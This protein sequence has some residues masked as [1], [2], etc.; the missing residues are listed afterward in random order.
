MKPAFVNQ[1]GASWKISVRHKPG[2]AT[3]TTTFSAAGRRAILRPR[4]SEMSLVNWYRLR[5]LRE[6]GSL[7]SARRVVQVA[8]GRT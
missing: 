7:R 5:V 4:K 8:S 1:P 6:L 3:F 2:F